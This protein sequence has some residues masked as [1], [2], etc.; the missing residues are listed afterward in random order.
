VFGS[1][2]SGSELLVDTFAHYLGNRL[3]TTFSN[4]FANVHLTDM[5]TCYKMIRADVFK[6]IPLTAR[7]FGFEPEITAK[8]ARM[9]ARIYEVPISY[10]A[11]S[12]QA[13]KKIGWRDGIAALWHILR[14]NV[15]DR[16]YTAGVE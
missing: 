6:N 1:R 16:S 3:L 2:Y 8:L 10:Q 15:L 11:R 13:G 12:Y 5:E 7:R 9:R 4:I 14:F